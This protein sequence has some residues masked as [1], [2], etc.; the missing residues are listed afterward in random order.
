MN[1]LPVGFLLSE[2]SVEEVVKGI[3]VKD[4]SPGDNGGGDGQND[5]SAL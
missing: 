3:S 2:S 5:S 4:D 1:E